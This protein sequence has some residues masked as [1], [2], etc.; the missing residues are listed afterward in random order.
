ML[1]F[2]CAVYFSHSPEETSIVNQVVQVA[3]PVNETEKL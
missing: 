1:Q 3:R 2:D